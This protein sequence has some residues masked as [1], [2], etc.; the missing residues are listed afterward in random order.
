M[1]QVQQIGDEALP[2]DHRAGFVSV[3]GRPNVGKSTLINAYLGQ[4]V[5]IVSPK[6]QTTRRRLLG[7][8]TLEQ[9]QVILVDTPGIHQP[10][11]KLGEAM[12]KTALDA[13]PDA[14]VLLW[15]V[16]ASVPPTAE[17]RQIAALIAEHGRGIPLVLALNKSD[18]V[19]A[20]ERADRA[21][22]YVDLVPPDAHTFLSATE[23][24]NR[25]EVLALV[26]ALLPPG[27]RFYPKDQ[28]TDQ[29]ERGIAA[30]LI[31]EQVLLHTH[32][33]V[34]HSVD[35]IVDE[36]AV[37][38]AD[39]TYIHATVYVERT[40]QKGILLGRG[41]RMIKAISQAARTEIERLLDTRV[42]LDLWIKVRPKWRQDD[43]ELRRL[44]YR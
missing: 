33:E 16:D 19:S 36:F 9:A 30:E 23:G 6:P 18:L 38:S 17:D 15:V 3:V 10:F 5:S 35:V 42:Y 43:Q 32:Q 44:G 31:R 14:D 8:L 2:D 11:H 41:G 21:R 12:V 1:D 24:E 40:S 37:R 39:M 22:A 26:I 27:P 34:P 13:I 28:V 29:T 4:K 20:S 25:D 7:I